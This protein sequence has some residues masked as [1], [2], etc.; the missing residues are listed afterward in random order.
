[1]KLL[2]ISDMLHYK[3]TD[4]SIFGWGPTVTE[5]NHLLNLF[6][7]ITHIGT[8]SHELPPPTALPYL[9]NVRFIPLKETGGT[10]FWHKL[11]ILAES[12]HYI[13]TM[14]AEL[15][16]A[17][18][19]HVRCPANIPLLAILL[20]SFVRMPYPRWVKYA[21]NWR[22]THREAKSYAFQRWL[23]QRNVHHGSV[24]VNGRWPDQLSHIY[25]FLN[26]SLTKLDVDTNRKLAAGKK[27]QT[28]L[29]LLYVGRVEEAKGAGRTLR[30]AQKLKLFNIP[31]ELHFAGDGPESGFFQE[32]ANELGLMEHIAFHG[33]LSK[34]EL[35][36]L[37]AR[38]HFLLLPSTASEGWPKVLSEGMSFGVVPLSSN[39]SSIP[40][41]LNVF[42]TGKAFPP[43]DT[44]A[45]VQAI[46]GY[47]R[48]P[49]KWLEASL[50]SMKQS[51]QF[52]YDNYLDKVRNMFW[53]AFQVRLPGLKLKSS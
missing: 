25:S 33:W 52:T 50:A 51:E 28:P 37:Y 5:I 29:N 48:E 45:F 12:N 30:I 46:I 9:G 26:P 41:I 20:L 36:Q 6:D 38:A 4:G 39:I 10:T 15:P 13:S 40:Q 14:L 34:N 2:I 49:D 18:A 44:D 24:S 53:D 27:I 11:G 17:N 8:F 32:Q 19:V 43:E 16:K 21:G 1:M 47:W 31:F 7:E 35:V 22:P 3:N 42:G 23:L